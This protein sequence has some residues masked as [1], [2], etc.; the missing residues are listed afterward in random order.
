MAKN[1]VDLEDIVERWAWIH[2]GDRA[3]KKEK[4][5]MDKQQISQEVDWKRVRF[6]HEEPVYS[7]EP[8]KPGS[9]T[10]INNVL[11]FTTFANK[12]EHPQRYTFKVIKI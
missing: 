12:T 9:G 5:L 3:S 8:P 2:F 1:Q 6:N 11:F 7:P 4:K 10:P